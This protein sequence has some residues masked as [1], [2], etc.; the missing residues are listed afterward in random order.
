MG[1]GRRASERPIARVIAEFA[2]VHPSAFFV[3]VGAHDGTALDPLRRE[4]LRRAWRGILVEPVP[5]VFARLEANYDDNERLV[6]ENVAIAD[7]DGSRELYHLPPEPAGSPLWEWY[8]ALGSFRREVVASH[9]WLIPDIDERIVTTDVPCL[10]FDTL[11]RKHAVERVDVV[12]IDTEGYDLEIL[13]L[14][15]FERYRPRL[16]MYEHLHLDSADQERAR[17]LLRSR[18]YEL[19]GDGMDVLAVHR[20][21]LESHRRLR[22]AWRRAEAASNAGPTFGSR[23]RRRA[24][25]ALERLLRRRGYGLVRLDGDGWEQVLADQSVPLPAGA[26]EELTP[27][28]PRLVELRDAYERLDWPVCS[29]SRWSRHNFEGWLD[30][31]WFRGDT[32]YVWQYREAPR[33]SRLKFFVFLRYV[34]EHDRLDLLGRVGE[35]GAFGCFTYDFPGYPRC[36]RDLLDSVCELDF[37]DRHLDITSRE[38]LRVLDVGAGYGR[39]AHRAVQTLDKLGDYCCVDAVP[40]STFLSEYYTDFRGVS[41]PVRVVPLPEVPALPAGG[42]DLAVNVHSFSECPRA[43]IAWWMHELAR[44]EV[45]TLFV[46]PN[47]ASGFLSLETDGSRLDYLSVIED[48][49]YRLKVDEPMF[50][51]DS[52]RDLVDVHDRHYLFERVG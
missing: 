12:Q 23:A 6:F 9:R 16:V 19:V 38:G 30:L 46:V 31:K 1:I 43:A 27:D 51:D 52:V 10:T 41:P 5:Y 29:H 8:D 33:V 50:L 48:A 28:N 45:P 3:Q 47:E 15:D 2:R 20:S 32:T 37:L 13:E 35:D 42:F 39:L 22:R 49:G 36:S 7:H 26:A 44:L 18:D 25:S 24:R 14:I 4:I 21:A 40:E 11:C 34:V 17:E